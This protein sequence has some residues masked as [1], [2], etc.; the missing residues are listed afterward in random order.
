M[1]KNS[2][3]NFIHFYSAYRID[4]HKLSSVLYSYNYCATQEPEVVFESNLLRQS[5]RIHKLDCLDRLTRV[6]VKSREKDKYFFPHKDA[7]DR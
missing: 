3:K 7:N 6:E 2:G 4:G 5:V 1:L